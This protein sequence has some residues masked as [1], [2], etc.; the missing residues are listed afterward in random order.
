MNN[1]IILKN[2]KKIR[3]IY[4][5]T[6]KELAEKI[7]VSRSTIGLI[8]SGRSNPTEQIVHNISVSLGIRKKWIKTGEGPIK[9]S[10]EELIKEVIENIN[11]I[12][13]AEKS[14]LK[15]FIKLYEENKKEDEN[16]YIFLKMLNKMLETYI[17]G[18]KNLQGYLIIQLEKSFAEYLE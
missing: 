17:N 15:V 10:N 4:N 3:K 16:K 9:K 5:F 14:F 6:Q 12:E 13:E 18:D 7:S 2:I 11:N 1:K 8:E